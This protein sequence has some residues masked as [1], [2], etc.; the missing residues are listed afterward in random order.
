MFMLDDIFEEQ[1]YD[2]LTGKRIHKDKFEVHALDKLDYRQYPSS[3]FNYLFFLVI[4]I[5]YFNFLGP[6]LAIFFV[7]TK[8]TLR[9]CYNMHIVRFS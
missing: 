8:Q 2:G 5:V 7:F 4:H 6:V 3:T 9:L 1:D